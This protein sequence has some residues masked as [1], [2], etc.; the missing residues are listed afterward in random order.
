SCR[1]ATARELASPARRAFVRL[2]L[3]QLGVALAS[4]YLPWLDRANADQPSWRYGLSLFG[5]LRYPPGFPHF[6]YVNPAAPKRGVVRRSAPGTFD[7]FNVVVSGVKGNLAVGLDLIYDTLLVPALDE[8]TS[9]YGL[10][11]EAVRYPSNFSAVTYRLRAEATWHDGAPVT[12]DDVIFSF[13]TLRQNNPQL[14]AYY[15]HVVTAEISGER[16]VTFTFDSPGN[17]ELPQI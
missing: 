1:S 6:D 13:H 9:A 17:R 12:P 14:S 8:A 11:A 16:E 10:L 3:G 2:I 4:R 7:N 5:D 15:R